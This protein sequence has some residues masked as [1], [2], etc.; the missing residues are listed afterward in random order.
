MKFGEIRGMA[1]G[2]G[3]NT[4]GMNKTNVIQAIQ[5]EE[6]NFDCYSTDRVNICEELSCLWR[7]DCM[8]Q[9]NHRKT[10]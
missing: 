7:P 8:K 9:N 6:G 1:K 5:K 10:N 2:M 4:Y 3:V